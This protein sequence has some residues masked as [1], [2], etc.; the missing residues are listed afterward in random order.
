M[1]SIPRELVG[2]EPE[3]VGSGK[4]SLSLNQRL[5]GIGGS[6]PPCDSILRLRLKTI[7]NRYFRQNLPVPSGPSRH[8]RKTQESR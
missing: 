6:T 4:D 3:E 8:R 2:A 7:L 1:G 5:N